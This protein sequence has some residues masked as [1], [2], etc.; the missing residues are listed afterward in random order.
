[1][2][3]TVVH[4]VSYSDSTLEERQGEGTKA[5]SYLVSIRGIAIKIRPL[6]VARVIGHTSAL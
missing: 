5:P 6:D 1:M 2:L 4:Y 3:V